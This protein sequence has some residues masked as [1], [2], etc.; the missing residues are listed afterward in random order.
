M[1]CFSSYRY[2]FLSS[3]D[4]LYLWR[5]KKCIFWLSNIWRWFTLPVCRC[6]RSLVGFFFFFVGVYPSSK[7]RTVEGAVCRLLY[8]RNMQ[9]WYLVCTI[10]NTHWP[11][12]DNK[13]KRNL[14]KWRGGDASLNKCRDKVVLHKGSRA[15]IGILSAKNNV[16]PSTWS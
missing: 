5:P 1:S 3:S 10:I 15:S 6:W 12:N 14:L 2:R 9:Q 4:E 8:K 7:R 11:V 13:V 16:L